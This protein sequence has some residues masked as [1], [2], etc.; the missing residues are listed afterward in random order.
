MKEGITVK[1]STPYHRAKSAPGA[2]RSTESGDGDH[3]ET[4]QFWVDLAA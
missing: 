4:A 3:I 2:Q 1:Q